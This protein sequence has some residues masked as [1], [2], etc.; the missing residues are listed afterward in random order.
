MGAM[1]AMLHVAAAVSGGDVNELW[2]LL[3]EMGDRL[4][5]HGIG[6]GGVTVHSLGAGEPM[7]WCVHPGSRQRV[8]MRGRDLFDTLTR[9]AVA[10]EHEL[11]SDEIW[12]RG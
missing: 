3:D 8:E 12:R 9:A 11:P 4:K 6:E 1:S 5:A 10:A 7:R 2:D